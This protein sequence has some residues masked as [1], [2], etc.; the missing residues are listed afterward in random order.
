MRVVASAPHFLVRDLERSV[1][2][3]VDVLGFDE[4]ERWGEPP[5]FAMPSRDGFIVMLNQAKPEWVR[6]NGELDC[7][8][9]YFWSDDIDGFWETIRD[10]VDVVHGPEDRELYGM[11]EIAI[12]DPDGYLLVFAH[13]LE[14]EEG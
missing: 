13:D 4:P 5:S 9:A 3:Y 14:G 8:D 7:W 6:P 2:F 10:R 1:R 12:R 11:R